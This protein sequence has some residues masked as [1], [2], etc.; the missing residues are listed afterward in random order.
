MDILSGFERK[1]AKGEILHL[2]PAV[3]RICLAA[4]RERAAGL[5]TECQVGICIEISSKG[6]AEALPSIE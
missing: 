2:L 3:V 6:N 5:S 1:P 4:L